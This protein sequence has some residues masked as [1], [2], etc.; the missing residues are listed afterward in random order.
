MDGAF[1]AQC[2]DLFAHYSVNVLGADLLSTYTSAAPGPDQGL[3]GSLYSKF[4]ARPG[5]DKIYS[6]ASASHTPRA[7][8][9]AIWGHTAAH[10]D[11]H[12]AICTGASSPTQ[13]EVVSL[14][15]GSA[16]SAWGVTKVIWLSKTGLYGYLTPKSSPVKPGGSA[17]SS[18]KGI[19]VKTKNLQDKDARA[20][21]RVIAPQGHL[22]LHTSGGGSASSASDVSAGIGPSQFI[23]H[24]YAKAAPGEAVDVKLSFQDEATKPRPKPSGHYVERMVADEHGVINRSV[25]FSRAVSK[26]YAVYVLAQSPSTNKKPVTVTVLD[27]DTTLFVAA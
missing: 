15:D 8:D 22:Y 14:N 10:P 20:K 21:G 19:T 4:P 1:G 17:S 5:I 24:V 9:V 3:A 23:V 16:A 6:R 7:G 18:S 13:I 26:G 12:V 11:T 2:W 25:T 27:C